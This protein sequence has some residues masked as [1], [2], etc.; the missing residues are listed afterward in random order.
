MGEI[1]TC[2]CILMCGPSNDE[3]IDDVGER[4][5]NWWNRTLSR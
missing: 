4:E 3:K 1:T 5:V 2:Y